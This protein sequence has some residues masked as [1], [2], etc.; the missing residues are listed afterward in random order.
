[1]QDEVG[2]KKARIGG[3]RCGDPR[4]DW[5]CFMPAKSEKPQGLALWAAKSP[6]R[7]GGPPFGDCGAIAFRSAGDARRPAAL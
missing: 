2:I 7:G 3:P 5:G 4:P 6:C 1:L